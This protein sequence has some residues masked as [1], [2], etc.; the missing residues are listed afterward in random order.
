MRI[1]SALSFLFLSFSTCS[2]TS[3]CFCSVLRSSALRSYSRL[4]KMRSCCFKCSTSAFVGLWFNSSS[5]KILSASRESMRFWELSMRE[6]PASRSASSAASTSARRSWRR[7]T[8]LS[9]L[10][11]WTSQLAAADTCCASARLPSFTRSTSWRA[12]WWSRESSAFCA[13]RRFTSS[14]Y[15]SISPCFAASSCS[16]AAFS[17]RCW[18]CES[19]STS[20]TWRSSRCV[21]WSWCDSSRSL[22]LAPARA[23]WC[24]SSSSFSLIVTCACAMAAISP[25]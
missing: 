17:W 14:R 21:C 3:L 12:F 13:V 8:S 2:T 16:K 6:S 9:F 25:S 20:C 4:E 18:D 23:A 24:S 19:S 11:S 7:A 15:R 10:S 1:N 22:S 5:S